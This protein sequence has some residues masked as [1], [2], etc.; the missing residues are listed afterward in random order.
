MKSNDIKKY[1]QHLPSCNKMQ[2][3][4]EAE[5][6]LSDIPQNL[7]DIEWESAYMEMRV[8]MN[9][10]TCGLDKILNKIKNK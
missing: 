3:W 6:A 2:D 8:K 5:Q 10:C 9:T 7:R 4:T 1:L